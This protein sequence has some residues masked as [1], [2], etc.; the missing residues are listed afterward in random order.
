MHVARPDGLVTPHCPLEIVGY[1]TWQCQEWAGILNFSIHLSSIHLCYLNP[2]CSDDQDWEHKLRCRTTR[3]RTLVF[4]QI[5]MTTRPY[6]MV[7]KAK[8]EGL[9]AVRHGSLDVSHLQR[10]DISHTHRSIDPF[11][12]L[13][14]DPREVSIPHF[15]AKL[16]TQP[17]FLAKLGKCTSYTLHAISQYEDPKDKCAHITHSIWSCPKIQKS[18]GPVCYGTSKMS[19]S[20]KKTAKML[21]RHLTRGRSSVLHCTLSA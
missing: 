4:L 20:P 10:H 18:C 13:S 16:H 12:S 17:T 2:G 3:H 21:S 5:L 19:P 8:V 1:T 11:T 14:P 6:W 15:L 9:E 7:E